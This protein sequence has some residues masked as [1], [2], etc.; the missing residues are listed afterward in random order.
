MLEM[1]AYMEYSH[2]RHISF[3]CHLCHAGRTAKRDRFRLSAYLDESRG[4]YTHVHKSASSWA[5]PNNVELRMHILRFC[6]QSSF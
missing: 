2:W 5:A 1:L 6:M 4:T 3:N